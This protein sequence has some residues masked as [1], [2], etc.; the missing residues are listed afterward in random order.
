MFLHPIFII[1][2][3]RGDSEAMGYYEENESLED[4]PAFGGSS[5]A[6]VV[7]HSYAYYLWCGKLKRQWRDG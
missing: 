1:K 3:D 4:T 2:A 6:F 7:M 5:Y